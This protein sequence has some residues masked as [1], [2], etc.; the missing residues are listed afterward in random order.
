MQPLK[1]SWAVESLLSLLRLQS[2]Q[3]EKL[4]SSQVSS[5]LMR[6]SAVLLLL[7][8]CSFLICS[9]FLLYFPSFSFSVPCVLISGLVVSGLL[10]NFPPSV[11]SL[12]LLRPQWPGLSGD[13]HGSPD[14]H[15]GAVRH[16]ASVG[17]PG[18]AQDWHH[19]QRGENT[20]THQH[21]EHSLNLQ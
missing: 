1:D 10:T 2:W 17:S 16:R 21:T 15:P 13:P 12:H 6:G 5:D 3:E 4:Q 11:S 19:R 7:S 14:H 20:Q 9:S 8:L 18:A